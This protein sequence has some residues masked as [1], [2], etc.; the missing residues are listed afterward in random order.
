MSDLEK[1]LEN[2]PPYLKEYYTKKIE[3]DKVD[4]NDLRHLK[5]HFEKKNLA[6]EIKEIKHKMSVDTTMNLVLIVM[7]AYLFISFVRNFMLGN[8][9]VNVYVNGIVGIVG[10]VVCGYEL[11][12]EKKLYRL[13]GGEKPIVI[14]NMIAVLVGLLVSTNTLDSPIDFSLIILLMGLILT[15]LSYLSL[16]K[17]YE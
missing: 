5:R 14:V 13:C 11:Y 10:L 2:I 12:K 1:F 16:F 9:M 15:K 3:E 4:T 17:K 8:F 7:G 6:S